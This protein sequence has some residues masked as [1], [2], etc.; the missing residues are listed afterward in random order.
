MT[1][2][3]SPASVGQ[4]LKQRR[5]RLDFTQAAL[6]AELGITVNAVSNAERDRSKIIRGKRSGW[7]K[8]LRLKGGSIS[9]AYTDGTPIEP[10]EGADSE[11]GYPDPDSPKEV[12]VWRMTM[13]SEADRRQLIDDHRARETERRRRTG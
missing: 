1:T 7:E 10:L 2:P 11:R 3:E 5:E 12:A 13:L 9:R 6:A 8:A 4:Q